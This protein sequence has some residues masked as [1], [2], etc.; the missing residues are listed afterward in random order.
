MYRDSIKHVTLE[1][2]KGLDHAM[3]LQILIFYIFYYILI[4]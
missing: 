1:K 3:N 4:D 2:K